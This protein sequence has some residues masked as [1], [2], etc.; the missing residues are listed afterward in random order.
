MKKNDITIIVI[1][2]LFSGIA[3]YFIANAYLSNASSQKVEIKTI[4]AI[5]S[6]IVQPD[7]KIFNKDAINPAVQINIEESGNSQ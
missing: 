6:E 1:I 4:E 2:V 3:T 5:K 7:P